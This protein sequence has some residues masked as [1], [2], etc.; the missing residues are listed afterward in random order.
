MENK[1][2]PRRSIP[3]QEQVFFIKWIGVFKTSR[4]KL[5]SCTYDVNGK[6]SSRKIKFILHEY[7]FPSLRLVP[8]PT[9]QNCAFKKKKHVAVSIFAF[10]TGSEWRNVFDLAL[11]LEFASW[12]NLPSDVW[13]YWI[14]PAIRFSKFPV[15]PLSRFISEF[16]LLS[17]VVSKDNYSI[18]RAREA[19]NVSFFL[20]AESV[21]RV[22]YNYSKTLAKLYERPW[23]F[24]ELVD[25]FLRARIV[26]NIQ[27]N[28]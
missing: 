3:I 14:N 28:N 21:N 26:Q 22:V 20:D 6:H 7:A 24:L 18:F 17:G 9:D 11:N 1:L 23:L 10:W 8:C 19:I 13:Q 12:A 25:H 15:G 2:G 27:E 4:M 16:D 5:S